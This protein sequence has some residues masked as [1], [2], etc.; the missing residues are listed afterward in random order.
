MAGRPKLIEGRKIL[1]NITEDQADEIWEVI[2]AGKPVY[3]AA[4]LIEGVTAAALIEWL[5]HGDRIER[6]K[7]AREIAS[8]RLVQD[9]LTIADAG[10]A[11]EPAPGMVQISDPARD[12]LRIQA[13]QWTASR[14]NRETYGEQKGAQVTIN[15]GTLHLDALRLFEEQADRKAITID[16]QPE[17]E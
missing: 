6:Y 2:D 9:A 14:W 15:L 8:H 12:K 16:A 5:E 13:R 1:W 3:K 17:I 4:A 10:L 7:R 11:V